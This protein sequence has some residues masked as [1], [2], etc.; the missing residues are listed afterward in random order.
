MLSQYWLIVVFLSWT[1]KQQTSVSSACKSLRRLIFYFMQIPVRS[2][3]FFVPP[4]KSLCGGNMGSGLSRPLSYSCYEVNHIFTNE[5]KNTIYTN[6]NINS[7]SNTEN[8]R[9]RYATWWWNLC[10][11]FPFFFV[12][13]WIRRGPLASASELILQTTETYRI[14]SG[15][16]HMDSSLFSRGP[17][18]RWVTQLWWWLLLSSILI[19]SFLCFWEFEDLLLCLHPSWTCQGQGVV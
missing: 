17:R 15:R 5:T 10:M 19:R 8:K 16:P 13:I 1:D 14:F 3:P 11:I 9:D 2:Q 7:F 6:R 12:H 4:W 18:C